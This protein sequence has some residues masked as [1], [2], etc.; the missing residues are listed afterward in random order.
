MSEPRVRLLVNPRAGSGAPA[1]CLPRILQAL[2]RLDLRFEVS[3]TSC[4]GDAA[5]IARDS[6]DDGS[7]I[8]AVV[9]GDGTL[10]EAVQ[11]W[12]DEHGDTRAGPELCVIPTGTGG[13]FK[14]TLGLSGD[15][16]QAVDRLRTGTPTAV[17]LGVMRL[18]GHDNSDC[19]RAFINIASFGVGGVTDILVNQ[20][21][22]WLGGKISFFVGSA[23]ALA[24]Y[25]NAKVRVDV[26]G[27]TFL[28][29]RIFNVALANGRF[30]GGG[31]MIAPDANCSDGM[32][33]VV[34]LGDMSKFESLALSS[35]IYRG[36]HLGLPNVTSTR[37][38]TIVAVP[39]PGEA[40]VLLDVDG[41]T[42]GKLPIEV[43]VAAGLLRVRM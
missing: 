30:F 28:E 4:P 40:D 33:D 19:F 31:M 3:Q 12:I 5:R 17:D 6:F 18:T 15:L 9:G 7:D 10:N 38:R 11:A 16:D 22:K 43:H 27:S 36:A 37:G 41:E 29:G 13:D 39:A 2:R 14:R 23:R 1:R 26:D 24:R 8:L 35:K 32:L 21:P 42:P 34:A 20:A 25:S